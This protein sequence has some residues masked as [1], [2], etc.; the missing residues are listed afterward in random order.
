MKTKNKVNSILLKIWIA[1]NG[2]SKA[3]NRLCLEADVSPSTLNKVLNHGHV[4]SFGSA[5]RLCKFTGITINE[6]FPDCYEETQAS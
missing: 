1:E 2:D 6:L 3:R 4:P 5:Y